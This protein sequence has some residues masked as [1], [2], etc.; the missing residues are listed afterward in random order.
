[1]NLSL[2][3]SWRARISFKER[4]MTYNL[5]RV[6]PFFLVGFSLVI[7]SVAQAEES[8]PLARLAAPVAAPTYEPQ[9]FTF[10]PTDGFKPDPKTAPVD[11]GVVQHWRKPREVRFAVISMCGG[12]G[13]GAAGRRG[14]VAGARDYSVN[15]ESAGY[16][17]EAATLL[18]VLAGPFEER[19][20]LFEISIGRG[21]TG[22]ST[23][24]SNEFIP[25]RPGYPTMFKSGDGK[26]AF[27][28]DGGKA[29]ES[30]FPLTSGGNYMGSSVAGG[31]TGPPTTSD[32]TRGGDGVFGPGGAAK[33]VDE[34]GESAQN[35]CAG[36]GGSGGMKKFSAKVSKGGDGGNGRLTIYPLPDMAR[37]WEVLGTQS[38]PSAPQ[39]P[40]AKP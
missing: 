13:G 18:T 14:K 35:P 33:P 36:G 17:G 19:E 12:G 40:S 16:G 29:G 20:E 10:L 22:G 27:R 3:R 28:T 32:H 7:H 8:K 5:V 21:G 11:T 34:D 39:T 37:L 1:V 4:Y 30:V 25:P 26:F 31:F 15:G 23:K 38:T 2:T 9:T 6:C 24:R